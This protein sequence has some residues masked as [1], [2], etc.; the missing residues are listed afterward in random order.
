MCGD[1]NNIVFYVKQEMRNPNIF[2]TVILAKAGIHD[3]I[4]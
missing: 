1:I 3:Y 4:A 2:P